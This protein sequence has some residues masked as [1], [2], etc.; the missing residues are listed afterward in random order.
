[1]GAAAPPPRPPTPPARPPR[2]AFR[3]PSPF[4]AEPPPPAS[5][6]AWRATNSPAGTGTAVAHHTRDGAVGIPHLP[7]HLSSR[8]VGKGG[9]RRKCSPGGPMLGSR[10]EVPPG[11]VASSHSTAH[12][13]FVGDPAAHG[14]RSGVQVSCW[15]VARHARHPPARR[16]RAGGHHGSRAPYQSPSSGAPHETSPVPAA[17]CDI[18]DGRPCRWNA[19]S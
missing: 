19:T 15:P 5:V 2:P 8:A 6:C 4:A 16:I 1:M 7:P 14:R 13:L 10:H 17:L 12:T 18:E 9:D 11:G 3:P